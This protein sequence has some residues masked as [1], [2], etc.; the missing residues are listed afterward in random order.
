MSEISVY[1]KLFNNAV[2][3]ALLAVAFF[4]YGKLLSLLFFMQKNQ[5]WYARCQY[6]LGSLKTLLASL[7]L[8]GLLGTI[9]GLL[10]TFNFMSINNGLDMQEMVSGGIATAMFTTQLGLVFVV[11]GVLLHSLL[12]SKTVTWKVEE[13]CAH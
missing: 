10:S 3:W 5:H 6:W 4:S 2:V 13:K 1:L 8:L 9:S 11:P 7:P 12:K